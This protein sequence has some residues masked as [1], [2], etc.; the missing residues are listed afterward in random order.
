[1]SRGDEKHNG[2]IF[3]DRFLIIDECDVYL[4]GSSIGWHLSSQ[5]STGVFRVK[6]QGTKDFIRSLYNEYWKQA[7]EYQIPVSFI[8]RTMIE[9]NLFYTHHYYRL[10]QVW[11]QNDFLEKLDQADLVEMILPT[12]LLLSERI[13][14]LISKGEEFKEFGSI[15]PEENTINARLWESLSKEDRYSNSKTKDIIDNI[16]TKAIF[17]LCERIF[18]KNHIED[19]T[20]SL[21]PLVRI[22]LEDNLA[23]TISR[24]N[25]F[26]SYSLIRQLMRQTEMLHVFYDS[27]IRV[28]PDAW[29]E[30]EAQ[31]W[32]EVSQNPN[33]LLDIIS[34]RTFSDKYFVGFSEKL[35][36][37]QSYSSLNY[38]VE[39][40][41]YSDQA[42]F[43]EEYA[44]KN[45]VLLQ[46]RIG[47]WMDFW[48]KLKLPFIQDVALNN[49]KTPQDVIKIIEQLIVQKHS[50]K[51]QVNYLSLIL[52]RKLYTNLLEVRQN[53]SFYED[54]R[55]G[56]F[57][58]Y[59]RNK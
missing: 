50:L 9:E 54:N 35:Q 1:M 48:D 20:N 41:R 38:I 57:L 44:F 25:R 58:I 13:F 31:L 22:W 14:L 2:W 18:F 30:D 8:H 21:Q 49:I 55:S 6:D 43:N 51:T 34:S 16:F 11:E 10:R 59:I 28:I 4:I 5:E 42:M 19:S 46:K 15:V 39:A 12:L 52:L 32:T 7:I 37:Y 3:H 24:D 27:F 40:T 26:K 33:D 36:K 45:E 56:K 23:K 53:L 29:I 47:L 17:S